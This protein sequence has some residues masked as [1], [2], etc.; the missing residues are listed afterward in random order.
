MKKA[1]LSLLSLLLVLALLPFGGSAA[2]PE[3]AKV[4]L[5]NAVKPLETTVTFLNSGAHPDDERSDFLAYLSRG[6]GVKTSSLIANR[7]EGGQNEIGDELDNALGIIRSREMIEAAKITGVKAYHLSETTSDPI[8]DF[9]F[10][11]TP[12]ETLGKWGEELTYERLIRFIRTYQPDIL[13]PSFQNDDTQHGHH[14]TMTILS[15]RAF[16]DAADPTVFP[17]QLKQG[18]LVWQVKKLYLPVSSADQATTS[19][20]IGKYDPIYGMT[21]PQLGE[22]S[23]YLHKSQGMGSDIPAAPRQ[24]HLDLKQSAVDTKSQ[25]D[26]FAGIPY[27]FT[28]WAEK[29]PR[30]A[31]KLKGE[32]KYLQRNLDAVIEAYPNDK[33]VFSTS[34]TAL[35]NVR[36]ITAQIKK[37][38]L[39]PAMKNDL[40]HKL[41]LKEEQL[42]NVSY[43]SSGLD[44]Q[45]KAAS[46]ILTKGQNTNVTITV[47]NN[48][49]QTLKKVAAALNVPKG[50]KAKTKAKEVNLAPNKSTTITYQVEVPE[51]AAYYHAYDESTITT[52]IS[53]KYG[54][55]KT[56]IM[57]ELDGT[58]AVL[59]D[60]GLN[61]SPED[62]VVNTSDVK[63]KIPV[64]VTLK[65]YTKGKTAAKVALKI[66]ENW[67]VHP[68][69]TT[70][71]FNEKSE[72]KQVKF[73]LTPPKA[74]QNG[75]FQVKAV[76]TVN[77]KT[78]DS[79]IQEISYDHIGTFYYRYPAAINTVA[80]EL[81][82]PAS[83]KVGYIES[84]FDKVADYLS[85]AGLNITKLTAADL[86][87]G[88][89]SQYDTIVTGI[90]AYLS[91]EDLKANNARLLEYVENGGHLVVQYH[92][93]GDGWDAQK[94]A[95]YP[96]TL[97]NPS[98]RW[99]VTD[100]NAT[101]NVSKPESALFNYPNKIT[102]DDWNNWVQERGLYFPM[103]WD[104]R[105]ETFIS[106]ADPNEE[107]FD[108]GI[109][110]AKYGKGTYLYTNLVLY[111]QIQGQVPG[112]YRI[113]TN[114]ISYGSK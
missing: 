111:R 29:L 25:S 44:V 108:G 45:A 21:Y 53:Y 11:K 97:G 83:L 104:E 75:E 106:M 31:S 113:M 72:E 49:K 68:K 50:W 78:F 42:Q 76:A 81:L 28:E 30:S 19:I 92:K 46:M 6:L 35:A 94:T 69:K 63:E 95:P 112:G 22:Q 39:S 70:V 33:L 51:D 82:M 99:R 24:V 40:L 90:R 98:I 17:K 64:T 84:G 7:G 102:T 107:P 26:L 57:E 48:G 56:A 2:N 18:L 59:P 89:L 100:E 61:L 67:E 23:R 105:F 37:A 13:M 20:E 38:K 5:W 41:S 96:L 10:S 85:N 103:K 87:E 88:D 86:A 54:S 77:G 101:V 91:R 109:L 66:P 8:Y 52:S 34:Q 71:S 43:V 74:I 80:F 15:E 3:E 32:F 79:T 14:R 114:L 12:E 73:T 62:I 47:R 4:E 9:G 60:V 16:K 1:F 93:P 27:D 58:I 36:S 110:M 55:T 65:N